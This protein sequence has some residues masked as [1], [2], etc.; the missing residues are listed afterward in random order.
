[1]KKIKQRLNNNKGFTLI[2]LMVAIAIL[3]ILAAVAVPSFTGLIDEA[4][5]TAAIAEARSV[6]L[7]AEFESNLAT[8]EGKDPVAKLNES[9]SQICKDAGV[10]EEDATFSFDVS[11]GDLIIYYYFDNG[12]KCVTMPG[13]TIASV[14]S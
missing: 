8:M 13:P 5:E 14:V 7:F 1:M 6:Y 9:W 10:K 3:L 11:D 2:E 12:T 4:N